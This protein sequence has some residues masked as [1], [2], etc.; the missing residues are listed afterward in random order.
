M[1]KMKFMAALSVLAIT[2]LTAC[3]GAEPSS[4]DPAGG[5][6]AAATPVNVALPGNGATVAA[7][8]G[9]GTLSAF[10]NDGDNS[11][12]TNFWAGNITGDTLTIDFGRLRNITSVTVYTNDTSFNS[13]APAKY[14][15]IS[16][17]NVTWKKTA[18]ITGADV[19]CFIYTSGSGKISCTFAVAQSVRYFRVRITS[20]SPAG[21]QIVEM[22]AQGS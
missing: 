7:S 16:A 10:V 21:Q 13:G 19:S 8:Y 17:D 5:T 11:T 14:I 18:Q 2:G 3:G 9:L 6:P 12:T 4:G 1:N 20:A 22:E 15:E